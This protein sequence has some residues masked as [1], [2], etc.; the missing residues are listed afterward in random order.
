MLKKT[1][2]SVV[3]ATVLLSVGVAQSAERNVVMP[4]GAKPSALF[5][6][7]IEANGF[8]FTS[9]QLPID[10]ATGKMVEGIEAQTEQAIANLRTVLEAGGSSLDKLVKV[11]IY[12]NN[13]DDYASMNKIYAKAFKGAPPARTALQVGKIPLG[14]S[15]EI[16]GI[17]VK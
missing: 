8:V 17:A 4:E 1:C 5:S 3:M 2:L 15:I 12:L 11:N 7:A 16:E 14:A 13:I 9:G 6:P 10:P